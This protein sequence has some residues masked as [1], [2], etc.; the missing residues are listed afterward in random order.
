MN[1]KSIVIAV[2]PR[3]RERALPHKWYHKVPR[4]RYCGQLKGVPSLRRAT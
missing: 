2:L 1:K 3:K 4:T